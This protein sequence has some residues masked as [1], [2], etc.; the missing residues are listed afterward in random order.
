MKLTKGS[1]P[2]EHLDAILG[3]LMNI[4]DTLREI[5]KEQRKI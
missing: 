2:N 4:H 3:E 1:D 5:L